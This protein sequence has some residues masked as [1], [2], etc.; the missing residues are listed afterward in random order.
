MAQDALVPKRLAGP[1][2]EFAMMRAVEPAAAAIHSSSALL[3]IE[4]AQHSTKSGKP[5]AAAWSGSLPRAGACRP[6][7]VCGLDKPAADHFPLVESIRAG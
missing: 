6:I 7:F 3:R 1:P 4:M 5:G 2:E